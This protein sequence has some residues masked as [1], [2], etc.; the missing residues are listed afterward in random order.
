M[1]DS[2]REQIEFWNRVAC[3]GQLTRKDSTACGIRHDIS[4]ASLAPRV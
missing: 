3:A 1:N 2:N 4:G